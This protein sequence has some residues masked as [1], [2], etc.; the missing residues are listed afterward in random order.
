MIGRCVHWMTVRIEELGDRRFP[1]GLLVDVKSGEDGRWYVI[2]RELPLVGIGETP[3]EAWD[4]LERHYWRMER[5][6]H[7]GKPCVHRRD[8]EEAVETASAPRILKKV[9]K[10]REDD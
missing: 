10:L 6:I 2:V 4:D 9:L 8:E 7:I 3:A 1:E 5:W